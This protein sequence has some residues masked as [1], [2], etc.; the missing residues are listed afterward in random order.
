VT[1]ETPAKPDEKPWDRNVK[2]RVRWYPPH[3]GQVSKLLSDVFDETG[4]KIL[5]KAMRDLAKCEAVGEANPGQYRELP[6]RREVIEWLEEMRSDID[7]A[8]WELTNRHDAPRVIFDRVPDQ[9]KTEC[10]T[11]GRVFIPERQSARFCSDACRQRA[12]RERTSTKPT[13]DARSKVT[14]KIR[15]L[16]A[17]ADGTE[18]PA[19]AA[20]FRS[21]AEQLMQQ[22]GIEPSML[23]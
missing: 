22:H 4:N 23:A 15:G 16:V 2:K 20:S 19:E 18:Y 8:I 6:E 11:C 7:L 1:T 9:Y 5:A 14:E 13:S 17:K 12:H 21:K 3:P 10:G